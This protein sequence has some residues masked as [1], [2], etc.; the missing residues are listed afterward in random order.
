MTNNRDSNINLLASINYDSPTKR[1]ESMS[2]NNNS[3][4]NRVNMF[5]YD[6]NFNHYNSNTNYKKISTE[7]ISIKD[8]RHVPR[9]TKNVKTIEFV[10]NSSN[11]NTIE[12]ED[13]KL[14]I[15]SKI[16][17]SPFDKL[18]KIPKRLNTQIKNNNFDLDHLNNFNYSRSINN[19]NNEIIINTENPINTGNVC[20]TVNTINTHPNIY[21]NSSPNHN[22]NTCNSNN[23][24][25][26]DNNEVVQNMIAQVFG[27]IC[28]TDSNYSVKYNKTVE[29][30]NICISHQDHDKDKDKDN[31]IE[32]INI[33][34]V[35][36]NIELDIKSEINNI[37]IIKK[38]N[39][40]ENNYFIKDNYNSAKQNKVYKNRK[41]SETDII[42]PNN[43]NSKTD[44][45]RQN[46]R[47]SSNAS[48]LSN[49]SDGCVVKRSMNI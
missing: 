46:S 15:K 49:Q 35:D 33:S 17:K 44:I 5:N 36:N 41:M 11:T 7:M 39:N 4:F 38:N 18:N 31:E 28:Q 1:K 40:L 9:S 32:E 24:E 45:R 43:L 19:N 23:Y 3:K 37:N 10:R 13:D 20:N 22:V 42:K 26:V 8:K 6:D 14:I 21:I 48:F 25:S 27:G 34:N 47:R 16:T 2:S 12:Q 30:N 29:N